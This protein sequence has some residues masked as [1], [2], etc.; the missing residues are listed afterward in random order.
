MSAMLDPDS[1]AAVLLS[2]FVVTLLAT[3]AVR[4]RMKPDVKAS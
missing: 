3:L 2:L 1:F 4:T